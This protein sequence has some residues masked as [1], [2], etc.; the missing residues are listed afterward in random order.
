MT[1]RGERDGLWIDLNCDMGESFGVYRL[2]ADEEVMPLITSANVACGFHGG[3]PDVMAKTVALAKQHG[4][5]VGAH[6]SFPDLLGFGRWEMHVPPDTLVNVIVYQ[7]GALQ[8]FCAREGVPLQHVK[9]HGSLNNMADK[10]EKVAQAI[11]RACR[12]SVPDAPLFVKPGTLLHAEAAAAG[13]PVVMEVYADRQYHRD[14]TLVSRRHPQALVR[15]PQEA[16]E[17]MVRL[18]TTGSLESIEGVPVSLPAQSVCVH[19]DTPDAPSIIR[20]L[21]DA[22]AQAGVRIAPVSQWLGTGRGG[23]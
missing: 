10:D 23:A 6:V 17:R 8:A 3:D 15:D 21:R 12:A 5:G 1:T 11:V 22:L 2:G 19:G 14:G 20:R 9:P 4:V 18:L 7:I 16:A 13:Q